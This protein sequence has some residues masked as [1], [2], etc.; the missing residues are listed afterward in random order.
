MEIRRGK[1]SH[2]HVHKHEASYHTCSNM[3]GECQ[4]LMSDNP[5]TGLGKDDHKQDSAHISPHTSTACLGRSTGLGVDDRM[6]VGLSRE[7]SRK[8]AGFQNRLG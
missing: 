2:R 6:G 8:L 5:H 4:Q 3:V 7:S 1:P